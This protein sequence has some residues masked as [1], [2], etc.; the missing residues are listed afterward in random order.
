MP[1]VGDAVAR[2]A[3]LGH[4]GWAAGAQGWGRLGRATGS[5]GLR[6]PS[7]LLDPTGCWR[8]LQRRG[9]D[10]DFLFAALFV[11][12]IFFAVVDIFAVDIF[13]ARVVEL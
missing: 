1:L 7:G 11:A 3:P 10:A 8:P 9:R 5:H 4:G 2:G 6:Q 13:A 12:R